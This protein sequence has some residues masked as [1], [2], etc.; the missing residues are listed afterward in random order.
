MEE[1]EVDTHTRLAELQ[2]RIRTRRSAVKTAEAI[3]TALMLPMIQALG[4]DPFDP[5]EVVPSYTADGS[6]KVDYAV[7]DG[8]ETRIAV[9]LTSTPY[10]TTNDRAASF[11]DAVGK[12]DA[13]CAILT[14]GTIVRVHGRGT[15]AVLDP[16]A[17]L[18]IDFSDQRP[19]ETSGFEHISLGSFDMAALIAG[20]ATRKAREAIVRSIGDELAD[21][22]DA[23]IDAIAARLTAAGLI[24]PDD[25]Q[26]LVGRVTIPLVN[27]V[28][29][30]S[31]NDASIETAT[32]IAVDDKSMSA[33][34]TLAFN[35]VK[36]MCARTVS[37]D[38]I[39]AR[40][41]KSYVAILLDDNNRRQIARIHFKTQSVKHLGRFTG[42]D[43]VETREKVSGPADIYA[44]EDMITARIKELD[45]MDA[46]A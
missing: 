31:S 38:R 26:E 42:A 2:A 39:V 9:L 24:R 20:A 36:A 28:G 4:Y 43:N 40:P 18:S 1:V 12:I 44:H 8:E 22:S 7:R 14:D 34:E 37:P 16:E 21:P 10:E 46:E 45:S 41:A 30:K 33:D 15:D 6:P 27:M 11:V 13:K 25:I 32:G 29:T 5:F 3:K 17:L 19:V 35:I 23:F